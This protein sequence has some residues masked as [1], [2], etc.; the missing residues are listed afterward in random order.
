MVRVMSLSGAEIMSRTE[1]LQLEELWTEAWESF[2]TGESW[3][4]VAGDSR[5]D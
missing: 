3:Q 5:I 2:A 1:V 4:A